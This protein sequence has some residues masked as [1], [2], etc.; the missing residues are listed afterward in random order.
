MVVVAAIIGRSEGASA[1]ALRAV[2]TGEA[3]LAISDDFLSELVRVLCYPHIEEKILRPVRAF[4]AALDLGT[5]GVMFHPRR[6]EWPSLRDRSDFWVLDLAYE[7]TADYIVTQ[8]E[9][10]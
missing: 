5:M 9:I 4:E 1:L 3:R 6:L 2:A 10:I 8:D 7:A